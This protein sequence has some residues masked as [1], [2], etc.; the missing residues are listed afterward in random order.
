M[1]C[2]WIAVPEPEGQAEEG[3]GG[4]EEGRRIGQDTGSSPSPSPPSPPQRFHR[5]R[6]GRDESPAEEG[7][8]VQSSHLSQ[9]LTLILNP[10]IHLHILFYLIFRGRQTFLA[11]GPH[12]SRY[13]AQANLARGPHVCILTTAVFAGS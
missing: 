7:R 9:R 6:H 4:A 8:R 11:R 5:G 13:E 2:D 12:E 3:H 10:G 1:C